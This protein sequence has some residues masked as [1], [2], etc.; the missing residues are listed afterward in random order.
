MMLQSND[1]SLS[2]NDALPYGKIKECLRH[3]LYKC[4]ADSEICAKHIHHSAKPYFI[5]EAYI[6]LR[7]RTSFAKHTSFCE[8]VHHSK[9]NKAFALFVFVNVGEVGVV[10]VGTCV[11]VISGV[12]APLC[13]LSFGSGLIKLFRNGVNL[14]LKLLLLSTY[15][16]V[17]LTF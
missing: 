9:T 16:L 14:L 7:S 5:C 4:V 2:G 15:S 6:I 3:E 17:I 13:L 1:A 8:A 11:S 10:Y 12:C